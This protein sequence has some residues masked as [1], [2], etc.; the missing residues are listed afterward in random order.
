MEQH[1]TTFRS[2]DT[3]CW[4]CEFDHSNPTMVATQ[5]FIDKVKQT[6]IRNNCSKLHRV[7]LKAIRNH[8]LLTPTYTPSKCLQTQ[9]IYAA[10][11]QSFDNFIIDG[12]SSGPICTDKWHAVRLRCQCVSAI[13][14]DE[15]PTAWYAMKMS[16]H[17]KGTKQFAT[18]ATAEGNC[19]ETS[20]LTL[21]SQ[22]S[23]HKPSPTT[24]NFH[25]KTFSSGASRRFSTP[26]GSCR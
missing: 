19:H 3:T 17:W 21:T 25:P 6:R 2:C 5:L 23:A 8:S 24:L 10:A 26:T 22:P 11:F 4:L 16:G 15:G 18:P 20:H 14:E 12:L 9:L 13:R 7:K 1:H